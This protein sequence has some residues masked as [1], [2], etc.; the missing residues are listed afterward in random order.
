MIVTPHVRSNLLFIKAYRN[1]SI[2]YY[3]DKANQHAIYALGQSA[4]KN[5]VETVESIFSGNILNEINMVLLP[6]SFNNQPDF[7]EFFKENDPSKNNDFIQELFKQFTE[8]E[9]K[10]VDTSR[11]MTTCTV[12]IESVRSIK[13]AD[14]QKQYDSKSG[15]V[16]TK[17]ID[18]DDSHPFFQ[19]DIIGSKKIDKHP[20]LKKTLS[21]Y[22]FQAVVRVYQLKTDKK[23][24][25]QSNKGGSP[26]YSQ[27][28]IKFLNDLS[29]EDIKTA[30]KEYKAHLNKTKS[31]P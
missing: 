29:D 22:K 11:I 8:M 6:L 1:K 15:V 20:S 25:W 2:H 26:R 31:K 9:A 18:P 10:S 16:A 7:I 23:Y 3:G 12:K 21:S 24:C 14:F 5:Y 19:K 27:G 4:I 13:A 28:V 17:K 30:V